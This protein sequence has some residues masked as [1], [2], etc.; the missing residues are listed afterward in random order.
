MIHFLTAFL[1]LGRYCTTTTQ[2]S[3]TVLSC[4]YQRSSGGPRVTRIYLYVVV[5]T[6]IIKLIS[7]IMHIHTAF[8]FYGIYET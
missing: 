5:D 1:A 7:M 6:T 3:C 4:Q 2:Y 8:I